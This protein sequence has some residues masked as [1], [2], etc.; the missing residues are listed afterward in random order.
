MDF[1]RVSFVLSPPVKTRLSA[2]NCSTNAAKNCTY[3]WSICV[4]CAL[5]LLIPTIAFVNRSGRELRSHK[6]HICRACDTVRP[7]TRDAFTCAQRPLTAVLQQPAN[8][9]TIGSVPRSRLPGYGGSRV[10]A[11]FGYGSTPTA[12]FFGYGADYMSVALLRCQMSYVYL[13]FA[14]NCWAVLRIQ[15]A[16]P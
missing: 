11:S 14:H 6:V 10:R 15:V 12:C 16:F 7:F 2:L 13:L 9:S 3:I 4:S 5:P 1:L 8:Y